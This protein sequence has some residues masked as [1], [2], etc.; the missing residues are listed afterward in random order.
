MKTSCILCSH[1]VDRDRE[2]RRSDDHCFI[3][4]FPKL[5]CSPLPPLQC[6]P[7]LLTTVRQKAQLLM[8]SNK[9]N[10]VCVQNG[11]QFTGEAS[12]LIYNINIHLSPKRI[13]RLLSITVSCAHTGDIRIQGIMTSCGCL[14]LSLDALPTVLPTSREITLSTCVYP[15]YSRFNLAHVPV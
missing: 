9:N 8:G 4:S 14:E 1:F 5:S 2:R 10:A 7:P 11:H 12:L 3:G 6:G 13:V 15:M